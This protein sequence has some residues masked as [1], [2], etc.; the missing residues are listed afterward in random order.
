MQA[1]IIR[2]I[3][4]QKQICLRHTVL[5]T[6]LT[7]RHLYFAGHYESYVFVSVIIVYIH[8]PVQ[9]EKTFE[10]APPLQMHSFG[11]MQESGP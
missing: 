1:C 3:V 8:T 9:I 11:R 10:I 7:A 4:R 5:S 6:Q 2:K